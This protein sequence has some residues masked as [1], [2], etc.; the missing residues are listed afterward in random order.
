MLT[1]RRDDA[2]KRW[3]DDPLR[4][5]IA[6]LYVFLLIF[7][8]HRYNNNARKYLTLLL[9]STWAAI[10]IGTAFH[11]ATVPSQFSLIRGLVLILL[12]RMWGLELN[13]F[14]GVEYSNESNNQDSD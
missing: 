13:N 12:G 1:I 10:E 3:V 8:P 5:G 14:A 2:R 7:I 4:R 11:L 9:F 6:E